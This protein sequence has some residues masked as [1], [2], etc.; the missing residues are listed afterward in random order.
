MS[1]LSFEFSP[2]WIP[3]GYIYLSLLSLPTS[4]RSV[5]SL[6][7]EWPWFYDSRN[8]HSNDAPLLTFLLL[9]W[10]FCPRFFPWSY[11]ELQR[12]WPFSAA[13]NIQ[14]SRVGI[15]RLITGEQSRSKVSL[16][17]FKGTLVLES[18]LDQKLEDLVSH[19]NHCSCPASNQVS[20]CLPLLLWLGHCTL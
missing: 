6:V 13:G 7:R 17:Y 10:A 9:S 19:P 2:K 3:C 15:G 8:S 20:V 5:F 11:R 4:L 18:S 16:K 14:L 1:T 12:D